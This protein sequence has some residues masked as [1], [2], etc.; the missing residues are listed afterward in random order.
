MSDDHDHTEADV[1]EEIMESVM[2]M[3]MMVTQL[4]VS[5]VS[6]WESGA[7]VAALSFA[8][9]LPCLRLSQGRFKNANQCKT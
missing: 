6:G 3:V 4:V 9:F 5:G 2:V 7:G 8:F 1:A